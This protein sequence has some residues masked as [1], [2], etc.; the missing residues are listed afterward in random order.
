MVKNNIEDFSK[1]ELVVFKK[2]IETCGNVKTINSEMDALIAKKEE[3]RIT[4]MNYR[5]TIELMEQLHFFD[6]EIFDILKSHNIKNI[7]DLIDSD[8]GSWG[9][10]HQRRIELEEA[11]HW[12]NFSKIEEDAKEN[13]KKVN[14]KSKK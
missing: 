3:E 12:Y 1:D 5:L 8:L 13:G 14:K 10:I 2:F 6:S 9:L 7:Q 4:S 11:K